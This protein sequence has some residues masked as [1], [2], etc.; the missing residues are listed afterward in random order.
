[1]V[2]IGSIVPLA[3]GVGVAHLITFVIPPDRSIE[4]LYNNMTLGWAVPFVLFIALA[5][6]IA[7]EVLFR[8]YM[9][10]RFLARWKPWTAILVTS[11]IFAIYHVMPHAMGLALVMGIWLGYMAWRSGSVLPGMCC[12]VFVN[13]AWNV[14]NIGIILGAFPAAEETPWAAY[15]VVG[16]VSLAC[17][18]FAIRMLANLPTAADIEPPTDLPSPELSGVTVS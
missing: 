12:H 13:G 8:G 1:L 6:G 14:W 5:P 15:G 2:L 10:R 4:A 16:V 3:I 11:V 18:V 9:Q 7:E 17:M